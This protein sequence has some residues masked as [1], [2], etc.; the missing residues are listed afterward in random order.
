MN[1]LYS[2]VTFELLSD[3]VAC[4]LKCYIYDYIYDSNTDRECESHGVFGACSQILAEVFKI[5]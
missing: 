3:Q 1:D 2:Q 5:S 4:E